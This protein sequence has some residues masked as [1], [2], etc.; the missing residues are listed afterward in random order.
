M[1]KR[2]F[3]SGRHDAIAVLEVVQALLLLGE[4]FQ[5]DATTDEGDTTPS[6]ETSVEILW[7]PDA[8]KH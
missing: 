4:P 7:G 1:G 8:Y 2:F 3:G 5:V 6:R